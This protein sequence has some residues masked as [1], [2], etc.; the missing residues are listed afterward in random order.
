MFRKSS[1]RYFQSDDVNGNL[2]SDDEND[3]ISDLET[4]SSMPDLIAHGYDAEAAFL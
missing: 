4:V 1:S 2:E 3:S